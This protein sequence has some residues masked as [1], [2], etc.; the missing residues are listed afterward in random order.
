MRLD[1]NLDEIIAKVSTGYRL[2][3]PSEL[4]FPC[5]KAAYNLML[6]CWSGEPE[7]RPS[8][9]DICFLLKDIFSEDEDIYASLD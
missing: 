3:N 2:P 5:E 7:V 4:G 1:I 6:A 9:R 8:F